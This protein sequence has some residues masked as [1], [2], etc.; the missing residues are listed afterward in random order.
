MIEEAI[1]YPRSGENASMTILIGGV[2]ALFSFLIV[3]GL[4]LLG[5]F[6]R[7]LRGAEA[8]EETPPT[9]GA[10]GELLVD[11]VKAFV[12]L[13]VY[14]IVPAI[15][16]SVTTGGLIAA[17]GAGGVRTAAVAGGLIGL[18]VGGILWLA[19]FYVI[20]AALASL[21]STD[22][23]GSAFDTDVL[24]VVLTDGRY[25]T[26]WLVALVLFVLTAVVVTVLNVVPFLGFVV[27]AF[28]DFYVGV[29]AAYLYGHAFEDAS[30]G[31]VPPESGAHAAV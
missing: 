31:E 10:W 15:V 20:P 28:L 7:V 14:S 11:G 3:P 1:N 12:V 22:R 4:L 17:A 23:L 25:A 2:L 26:G 21:A 9:F 18:L 13:L 6:V 24:W 5:Y 27:G 8:G 16:V 29:A 30:N 19:A